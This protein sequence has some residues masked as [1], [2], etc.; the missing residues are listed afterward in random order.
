MATTRDHRT[1][2]PGMLKKA[3]K[4]TKE[5][6]LRE[7]KKNKINTLDDLVE[8]RLGAVKDIGKPIPKSRGFIYRVFILWES[9]FMTPPQEGQVAQRTD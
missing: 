1:N 5:D 2:T 8:A 4:L 6:V 9:D 7:L 3:Q